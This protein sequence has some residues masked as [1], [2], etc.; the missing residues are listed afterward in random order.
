MPMLL[1]VICTVGIGGLLV[2]FDEEQHVT[3]VLALGVLTYYSTA[4]AIISTGNLNWSRL[5]KYYCKIW[6]T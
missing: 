1:Y 6:V 4:T 5:Y 2:K 3:N